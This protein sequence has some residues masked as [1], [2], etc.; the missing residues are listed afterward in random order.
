[1]VSDESASKEFH[2]TTAPDRDVAFRIIWGGDART[3]RFAR[4]EINGLV[5]KLAEDPN[6]LALGHGGDYAWRTWESKG[7]AHMS[8]WLSD[9]E[10]TVTASGRLLPII[11][12]RGDHETR[13]P[14]YDEAFNWPGRG[15]GYFATTLSPRVL[16]VTLNT[17][18]PTDGNQAAFLR[19]TLQ[20]HAGARWKL[21]QYHKPAYPAV[22]DEPSDAKKDWVPLFEEFNVNLVCEA[23]GHVIKRTVPIRNDKPA[24]DGVVYIGEGGMG[25]P[26][27]TP[28]EDLWYLKPPGKAGRGYHIQVLGFTNTTL[29]YQVLLSDG[30]VFDEHEIKLPRAA[31]RPASAPASAAANL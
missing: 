26:L 12:A 6:L 27:R 29:S 21:A 14:Q 24:D 2:F 20:R 11:P 28:K 3:G 8:E 30:K 17:N 23:D 4:R 25:A 22:K 16:L 19:E 7:L 9:H 5:A 13:G 31:S 15:T 1:M 10:L 18:I